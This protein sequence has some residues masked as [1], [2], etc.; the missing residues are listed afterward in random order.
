MHAAVRP[1]IF[2]EI[3]RLGVPQ[4]EQILSCLDLNFR[5]N[6]ETPV[7][8]WLL[9]TAVANGGLNNFVVRYHAQ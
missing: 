3:E 8:Q 9:E 7:G 5:Y 2:Q 4:I 6:M 1:L